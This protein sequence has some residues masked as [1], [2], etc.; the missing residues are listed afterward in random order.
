MTRPTPLRWL[1]LATR[2]RQWAL[3]ER[4]Q[5][6]LDARAAEE[7]AR[8]RRDALNRSLAAAQGDR[9]GLLS[10]D[11]FHAG[12]WVQRGAYEGALR[13]DTVG[14]D[15][16]FDDASAAAEA[17]RAEMR[18][19]LAQRDGFRHR[20]EQQTE[21]ARQQ[22]ARVAVRELDELWLVRRRGAG[23]GTGGGDED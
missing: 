9:R 23:A 11:T 12:D 13:N 18:D 5:A 3:D 6:L 15:R 22:N 21:A 17:L 10:R 16:V 8:D 1:D 20:L 7:E 19:I 2:A 4:R 14:A